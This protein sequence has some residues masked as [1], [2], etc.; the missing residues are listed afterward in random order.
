MRFQVTLCLLVALASMASAT[1][2]VVGT[3]AAAAT[4][5]GVKLLAVKVSENHL[6]LE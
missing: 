1:V 4:L 6:L 5:L 2:I 3:S